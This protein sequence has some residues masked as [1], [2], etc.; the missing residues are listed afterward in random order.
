MG[1][2]WKLISNGNLCMITTSHPIIIMKFQSI[3]QTPSSI[4]HFSQNCLLIVAMYNLMFSTSISISAPHPGYHPTF[5]TV[6]RIAPVRIWSST[7]QRVYPFH[8]TPSSSWY[9]QL[10]RGTAILCQLPRL[11]RSATL[12]IL[13]SP[14]L[15]NDSMN[16]RDCYATDSQVFGAFKFLPCWSGPSLLLATA[17]QWIS[18]FLPFH[19]YGHH[20]FNFTTPARLRALS[21]PGPCPPRSKTQAALPAKAFPEAAPKYFYIKMN[22]L[23][24]VATTTHLCFEMTPRSTTPCTGDGAAI[25]GKSG[26]SSGSKEMTEII[27]RTGRTVWHRTST[28]WPG[29]LCPRG[30]RY[31]TDTLFP[32]TDHFRWSLP[33]RKGGTTCGAELTSHTLASRH[34]SNLATSWTHFKGTGKPT[35]QTLPHVR[36]F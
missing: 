15:Y 7:F 17:S 24:C 31:F 36:S 30:H 11:E 2:T 10:H 9:P 28:P 34:S 29:S 19:L 1:R 25:A 27:K 16:L 4:F 26:I 33:W 8:K 5:P 12:L 6:C 13:L 20:Y 3:V 23:Y 14:S 22:R 18:T 21:G 35:W 32:F